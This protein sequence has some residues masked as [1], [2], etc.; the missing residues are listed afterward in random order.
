MG[1]RNLT[2]IYKDGEYKL[3]KYCQ[4]DGYYE[5]Q[6]AIITNFLRQP[7][8]I[9]KLRARVD[10]LEFITTKE[11]RERWNE[12]GADPNKDGVTFEVSNKFEE[13]YP[14]LHRN[15]G[16]DILEMIVNSEG[17]FY[18]KDDLDFAADSL[19]CEYAYV[20]DFDKNTF[21][22]Y[23][24]FNGK[25]LKEEDRFYFLNYMAKKLREDY[26]DDI[27]YPVKIKGSVQLKAESMPKWEGSDE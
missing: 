10:N 15:T 4:W 27:Y 9:E 1:T 2:L 19:F 14:E 12:C 16:G 20:I 22:W 24:G 5:G 13:K 21:E 17:K 26:S 23:E 11:I 25:P 18:T 6:G 7:G 3:A 8:N